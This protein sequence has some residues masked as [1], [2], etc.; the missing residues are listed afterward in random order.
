MNEDGW[1][2]LELGRV[3]QVESAYKLG[4]YSRQE[5][6]YLILDVIHDPKASPLII[7]LVPMFHDCLKALY[8]LF[9]QTYA[10]NVTLMQ[11]SL[12]TFVWICRYFGFRSW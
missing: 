9:E 5:A 1:K 12:F 2:I 10:P 3:G 7:K 4:K 6:D 8:L 11:N